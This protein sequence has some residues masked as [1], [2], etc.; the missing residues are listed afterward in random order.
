LHVIELK[1]NGP[2]PSLAGLAELFRGELARIDTLLAPLGARLLP[3]A[4]HPWM[5]PATE[6]RLWPHEQNEIYAAYDRIFG[7]R[8]HGWANLQSMHINLP[9]A[10]DAEFARLHT[11]IRTVLPL[12]PALAAGSPFVDGRSSGFQDTRLELYRVNQRRVPEITGLVVPDRVDSIDEYHARIL[13]PMYA[14]IAPLDPDGVLHGEWLN[15]RGAIARFDRNAIEIRVLDAQECPAADLAIAQ[16]V[17]AVVRE[18]HEERHA[19]AARQTALATVPLADLFVR[20]VRDGE[21]VVVDEPDYLAALG[22]PAGRHDGQAVW[23]MLLERAAPTLEPPCA[24]ALATLLGE[25]PL[26]RRLLAAAGPDP[27]RERL[28]TLCARLCEAALSQRMFHMGT[29]HRR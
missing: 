16:A 19:P 23:R 12:L 8:G 22:L 17:C 24:D 3:G 28:R 18:L 1:T 20:A 15:S 29:P 2:A 10:G 4:M 26:A 27:D 13:A 11:A 21:R 7:C 14:A 25:G 9:F 5:D 6:Q